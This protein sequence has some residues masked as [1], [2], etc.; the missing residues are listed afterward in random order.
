MATWNNGKYS[1]FA[2]DAMKAAIALQVEGG[3]V[4]E[5]LQL[6]RTAAEVRFLI[7]KAEILGYTVRRFND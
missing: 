6:D 4:K 1:T 7:Q 3:A 2:S 5:V